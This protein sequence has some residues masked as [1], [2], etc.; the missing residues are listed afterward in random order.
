M[1]IIIS[2][3]FITILLFSCSEKINEEEIKQP[4]VIIDPYHYDTGVLKSGQTLANALI[5]MNVENTEVYKIVN[6][7]NNVYDLRKSHP[8]DSFV[9]KYDSLNIIQEFIY[10]PNKIKTYRVLLDSTNNYYTI[11]DTL[12]TEKVINTCEGEIVY[13]LWQAVIDSGESGAIAMMLSEIF[14]WDID[15]NIDPKKGDKFK[16]I[17]EQYNNS[18]GKFVKYGNILAANYQSKSY[19]KIAYRFK[20]KSGF[21]KYYD[22][23]GKAFQKAFLRTPLNFTR[24]TSP[25]GKRVHPITRKVR[26][27]NG[28]DFAA[29]YGTPV[30]SV[31][32]G[33]VI[34]ASWKGGHPTVNGRKGGYGKTVIIR[35]TNGYKTLY[36]HLSNYG[37]YKVGSRVKQHNVIGYVGS[38]GL[39]TGNHLHY[40]VYKNGKAINPMKIKN[41]SGPP[42]PKVEMASFKIKVKEYQSLLERE[43]QKYYSPVSEYFEFMDEKQK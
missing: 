2:L 39:S 7:L 25:F 20:N 29:H 10:I 22:S 23:K 37:K 5:E 33:T 31:A 18:N 16:I 24:I 13:S 3:I 17:Y 36:G 34:H 9:V 26:F 38:T 15:F 1:K 40:T 32:D 43:S 14:Q 28:V 6:K 12:K 19:D 27:H 11:V 30:E 4:P 42:V 8:A 21:S 35:H 41:V